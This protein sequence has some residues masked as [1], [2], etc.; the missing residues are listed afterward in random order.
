MEHPH[1][2]SAR[3]LL[4]AAL[5]GAA[6]LCCLAWCGCD[7]EGPVEWACDPAERTPS[8]SWNADLAMTFDAVWGSSPDDIFA[9]GEHGAIVHFDG[10]RWELMHRVTDEPLTDIWGSAPDDLFAV[11]MMGTILHFDGSSWIEMQSPTT[12]TLYGVHGSGPND[13]IAVGEQGTFIRYSQ[14]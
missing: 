3:S 1:V 2:I 9:V 11:G 14:D 4:G 8:W 7:E 13:V 12:R 10:T 6:L 5:I